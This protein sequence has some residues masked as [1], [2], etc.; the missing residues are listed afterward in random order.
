MLSKHMSLLDVVALL[1]GDT[2]YRK[3]AV[4]C[5]WPAWAVAMTISAGIFPSLNRLMPGHDAI[6]ATVLIVMFLCSAFMYTVERDAL[7]LVLLAVGFGL[8]AVAVCMS[9][10]PGTLWMFVALLGLYPI[11]RFLVVE[12]HLRRYSSNEVK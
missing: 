3:A 5:A 8:T 2:R 12:E 6:I 11:Y 7:Q 10:H 4:R 9:Q 1:L